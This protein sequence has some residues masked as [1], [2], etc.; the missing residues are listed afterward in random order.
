MPEHWKLTSYIVISSSGGFLAVSMKDVG[1]KGLSQTI[2]VTMAL[3]NTMQARIILCLRKDQR[4]VFNEAPGNH[5]K[6]LSIF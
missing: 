2:Y 3:N 1:R 6:A 4:Y 5:L